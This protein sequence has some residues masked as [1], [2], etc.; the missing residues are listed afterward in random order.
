MDK[1]VVWSITAQKNL[2]RLIEWLATN[3]SEEH[4]ERSLR[5]IMAITNEV[6][7]HPTKGMVINH[8]RNIRRWRVDA[9]NYITYTI[10]P[11]GIIIKNI[12]AYN[13]NK[14]GF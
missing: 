4:A 9:H 1:K 12:L 7:D 6:A 2:K 3:Y 10:T 8:E 14:K 13:M 5:W 11:N